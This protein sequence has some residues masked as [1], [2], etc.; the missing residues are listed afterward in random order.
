LQLTEELRKKGVG[1]FNIGWAKYQ[2]LFVPIVELDGEELDGLTDFSERTIKVSAK[3]DREAQR[4]T[5]VHEIWHVIL[6]S[7]WMDDRTK[8]YGP[9]SGLVHISNEDLAEN[10]TRGM[11]L[12]KNLNPQLWDIIF[13]RHQ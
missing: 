11:L 1:H 5:L 3:L 8:E 7:M 10:C 2:I 13:Y 9:S 6:S 12:F 4:H